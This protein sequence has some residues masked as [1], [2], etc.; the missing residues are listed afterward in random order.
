VIGFIVGSIIGAVVVLVVWRAM[1]HR[2]VGYP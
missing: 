1:A 2:R